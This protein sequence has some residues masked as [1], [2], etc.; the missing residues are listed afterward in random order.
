VFATTGGAGVSVLAGSI[1]RFVA[2]VAEDASIAG[3]AITLA[4]EIT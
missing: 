1:V 4:G 2:P 3:I